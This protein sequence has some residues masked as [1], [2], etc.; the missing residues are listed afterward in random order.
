MRKNFTLIELLVVIA[1]IAILASMLL[2]AL[3]KAKAKAQA[4]KCTGQLKQL[5]LATMIYADDNND[6][7]PWQESNSYDKTWHKKMESYYDNQSVWDGGFNCNVATPDKDDGLPGYFPNALFTTFGRKLSAFS[8]PSVNGMYGERRTM[9]DGGHW[10]NPFH[11]W[12][13]WNNDNLKDNAW[14]YNHANRINLAFM[15]GHAES[16]SL[17]E[18]DP[19]NDYSSGRKLTFWDFCDGD[20]DGNSSN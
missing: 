5:A 13:M 12:Y 4:I 16:F 17:G 6:C 11:A 19:S 3:G 14:A 2:P 18:F 10:M 9:Q 8:K 15:D 7:G 20:T 1:I